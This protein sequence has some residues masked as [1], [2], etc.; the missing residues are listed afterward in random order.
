MTGSG[1]PS[2]DDL[3]G[4]AAG[5][6]DRALANEEIEVACS[7]SRS[8]SVRVYGGEVES[9]T[10]AENHAIGVRVLVDGREGFASAGTLD[11]DVVDAMLAEARDNARFAEADPHVG[12][13]RPDGV[14]AVAVDLWRDGVALTPNRDK[15]DLAIELERRVKAADTR[16]TGVRVAGYGDSA[17]A[18]ALASTAGIRAATRA[19]SASISVQALAR[20]GDRT[21][22]GYAWDGARE[23]ADIDLD[24]V[25]ARAVSHSVDLLGAEQPKT[26]T[27]D[28]VLD[29]HLAATVL[30]LVA[31][32]LTGDRVLKGRSPFVDRVG[33]S[34]A[35]PALTFLDDPTDP[36]S[37]GAD[38]HDG[39]GLAC[40]PV[41][42]V[43]DGVLQGFLHDSYTGR[44]SGFGSTGSAVRGTRGLPAPGLHALAVRP[45]SGTLDELIGGVEHGLLV[46]SLAGLHS[47]VNPV[48]G[49]FS[50]GVEGRMIR[51]GEVAEPVAECTIAST[52]QRLLLDVRAVGGEVLHLPSGVST[53]P[54]VIGGVALSGAA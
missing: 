3:L 37:L 35:A 6:V 34:V 27:V 16:V 40:R 44:R 36:A 48:S 21:Q 2:P 4:V 18:F 52:L 11:A 26:S 25:V 41:P 7:H 17:G 42:L 29:H 45:G 53:P 51:N 47:G 50:V 10:T 54:V 38:S 30:G 12:I 39:E 15:I 33:E 43:T 1:D 31:G 32:T 28:L 9:L 5:V 49:D 19:T 8:T 22:T 24:R 13:A 46:F 14:D 23:P 20:D